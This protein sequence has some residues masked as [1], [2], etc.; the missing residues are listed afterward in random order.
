MKKKT[1]AIGMAAFLFAVG[2]ASAHTGWNTN[3]G[4]TWLPWQH[5]GGIFHGGGMMG[6]GYNGMMGHG[7]MG[8]SGCSM[9][10]YQT[11][12]YQTTSLNTALSP[13]EARS[14]AQT[15]LTT[16]GYQGLEIDEIYEFATHFEVE[17]EEEDTGIHA[18]EL[19]VDKNTGSIMPEMGPNMMW[20]T[21]YGHM[22]YTAGEMTITSD[23]ALKIAK[24][25]IDK[26]KLDLSVEGTPETYYGFYEVHATKDGKPV[27]Q[28]NINGYNGAV[29]FEQWHGE[30]LQKV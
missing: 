27:A 24:E 21:K 1:I 14:L 26:N 18:F 4:T 15:Y 6:Q 3:L 5:M 28:I 11:G 22:P 9:G 23:E 2:I 7:A 17:V 16:R 29:W 20:N 13:E 12:G 10:G 19:I 25:Y 8:Y 30:L